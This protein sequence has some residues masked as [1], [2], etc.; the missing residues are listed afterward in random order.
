MGGC[1][2]RTVVRRLRGNMSRVINPNAAGKE[3]IRLTKAIVITIR[4]LAKQTEPGDAARDMAAFIALALQTIAEGIDVSVAAWEK[5]D[6]WV[7]A[8]RFRMDWAWAGQLGKKMKTAVLEEDW[9]SVAALSA[10]IAQKLQKVKVS[11]KHRMGTPWV[12]AWD[13]LN[14]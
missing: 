7:K 9:A 4:E 13:K 6:Y 11:D 10:Q 1:E 12:G 8:D 2:T 3:R 5:R 14:E